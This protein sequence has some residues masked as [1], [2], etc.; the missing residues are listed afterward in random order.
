MTINKTSIVLLVTNEQGIF[1]PL[2]HL[3]TPSLHVCPGVRIC[4]SLNSF[5]IYAKSYKHELKTGSGL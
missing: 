5:R 2:S 4:S 3:S 1:I